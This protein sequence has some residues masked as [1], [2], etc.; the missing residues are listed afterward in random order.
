MS[1]LTVNSP[2]SFLQRP[3]GKVGAAMSVA[4]VAALGYGA[5]VVLP[6]LIT[7]VTNVLYLGAL[8]AALGGALYLCLDRRVRAFLSYAYRAFWRWLVGRVIEIDPIGIMKS[9]IAELGNKLTVMREQ[10]GALHGQVRQIERVM[11]ENSAQRDGAMQL[12]L[13]AK[14]APEHASA[15]RLSA[16]RAVKL[17]ESNDNLATMKAQLEAL[18]RVLKKLYDASEMVLSDMQSTVDIKSRERASM[19]AAYSVYR[20]AFAILQGES[21]G[22]E[23]Y[24][25]ALEFLNEDYAQ[26]LG[27]IEMFMDFSDGLIKGADLQKLSYDVEAARKLD[28][29][30]ARL[31][32]GLLASGVPTPDGGASESCADVDPLESLLEGTRA[33]AR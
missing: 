4:L 5:Y 17:E 6:V 22:R 25:R 8:C 29:W 14:G 7:L 15:G 21:E 26:K 28:A 13:T 2:K 31:S 20:S 12:A 11:Q 27:E 23:M 9:H 32:N 1:N 24:D 3:E 33:K 10:L 30:E 18:F 19:K 16:R